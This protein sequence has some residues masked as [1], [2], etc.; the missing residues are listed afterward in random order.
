MT[1]I[2]ALVKMVPDL[3]EE[4]EINDDGTGLDRDWLRLII[5]EFD[6]HATEQA[7]LL[8]ERDGG[9]VTVIAPEAEG[10]EDMLFTIAAKGADHVIKLAGDFEEGTNNHALARAF[11]ESAKAYQPDLILTGVQANDDLD[12]PVGPLV[13]E[14]LGMPYVGYISG[15]TIEDG[16]AIVRK[17][18]PG[19]L[20]AEME[21]TLPAVLGI[22]AGEE[23]PRYVAISKV[24]QMM[25]TTE[26]EEQEVPDLDSSGG[27]TVSR[28]YLP[29]AA[30]R[31]EMIEGD[32]DEIAA[33]LVEIFKE[34][35]AL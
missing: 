14:H 4:L 24:R 8:K 29:E 7:I 32:E 25:K 15:V 18:Y 6:N 20:I 11:A 26:I 5:N 12:G 31:A 27:P 35:G 19:G 13:A 34:A 23:P 10:V 1:K 30:E 16:K 2:V 21:V 33:K 3:V 28:M 17:E 22:Q 9:E